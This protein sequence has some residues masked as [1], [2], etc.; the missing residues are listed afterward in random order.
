M[1]CHRRGRPFL[2]TLSIIEFIIIEYIT[3]SLPLPPLKYSKAHQRQE[4]IRIS[5]LVAASKTLSRHLTGP[6]SN[7]I[8]LPLI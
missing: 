3:L 6:A 7:E 8:Y 4:Q 1:G 5:R 2:N